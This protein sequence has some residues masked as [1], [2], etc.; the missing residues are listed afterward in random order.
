MNNLRWIESEIDR[1]KFSI[2]RLKI[3]NKNGDVSIQE[4][5]LTHL[6]QIKDILESWE[7]CKKYSHINNYNSNNKRF[8]ITIWLNT[9]NCDFKSCATYDECLKVKNALEVKDE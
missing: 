9:E 1:L 8:D 2:E 5:R 4:K 6:N 7:I 3:L